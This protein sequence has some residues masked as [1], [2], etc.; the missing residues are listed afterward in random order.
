MAT[1]N[2]KIKSLKEITKGSELVVTIS[3]IPT[4]QLRIG[5]LFVRLGAWVIGSGYAENRIDKQDKQDQ[6]EPIVQYPQTTEEDR[7]NIVKKT[8][9]ALIKM[10]GWSNERTNKRP[11]IEESI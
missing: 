2:Y 1:N 8:R 3:A 5:L 6:N 9:E 7:K 4:L 10:G 11:A